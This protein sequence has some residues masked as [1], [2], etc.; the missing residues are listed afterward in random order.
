M[1]PNQIKWTLMIMV[2]DYGANIKKHKA[3]TTV[4]G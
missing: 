2:N 3:L 1:L 4:S